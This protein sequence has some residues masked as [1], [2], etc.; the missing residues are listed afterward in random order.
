MSKVK[1]IVIVCFALF[2]FFCSTFIVF[3]AEWVTTGDNIIGDFEIAYVGFQ[4]DGVNTNA[5]FT[6]ERQLDGIRLRLQAITEN[7]LST[8]K[9]YKVRVMFKC[10]NPAFY[11]S[12][13]NVY[14]EWMI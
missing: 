6:G 11:N 1:K 14:L 7:N 12:D 5:T 9:D 8:S 3:G 10:N 13:S 4:A 2:L